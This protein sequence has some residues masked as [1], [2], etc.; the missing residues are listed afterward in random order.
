MD[1]SGLLQAILMIN[2]FFIGI[3]TAIAVRHAYAHFKPQNN[4]PE[5]SHPQT[6]VIH[7]SPEI[8][9][10]ILQKAQNNFQDVLDRSAVN[11]E[12]DLTTTVNQINH[13][14]EKMS[15]SITASEM[16]KY[17]SSLEQ[18]RNQ[19][20][21]LL[22]QAQAEI[23]KHQENLTANLNTKQSELEQKLEASIEAEK[24]SLVQAIDTKLA[25]AVSSFLIDTLGHNVDLGAQHS[26]LISMLEEHKEEIKKGVTDEN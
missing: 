12:H 19:M 16:Q 11:L 2:V 13:Q 17:N 23:V 26:Y 9:D 21:T 24:Q 6:P 5:K 3:I 20:E 18:L 25:D 1:G 22:K 4:E 14:L 10:K 8:R 15:S 7:I